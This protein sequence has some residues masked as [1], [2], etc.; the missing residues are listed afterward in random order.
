LRERIGVVSSGMQQEAMAGIEQFPLAELCQHAGS[1][2]LAAERIYPLQR[3][4]IG[5]DDLVGVDEAV[6]RGQDEPAVV[7]K[8]TKLRGETEQGRGIELCCRGRVREFAPG[9]ANEADV[10]HGRILLVVASRA[11]TRPRLRGRGCRRGAT[12]V[13]SSGSPPTR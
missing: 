1:P 5:L 9:A 10:Q 4:V 3:P 12:P 11:W 6:Q 8:R 13:A 2:R 7:A